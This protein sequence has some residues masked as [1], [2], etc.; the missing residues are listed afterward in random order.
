MSGRILAAL[1]TIPGRARYLRRVLFSL[2]PQVDRL[3]VYLNGYG[4]VPE[5]VA[6]LADEHVVDGENRGAERKFHWSERHRGLYFSCDDDL[7]YPP[8]YVARMLA[9]VERW[10]GD[11]IVTLHG[12]SYDGRPT[13]ISHVVPD[14]IGVFTNRLREGRWVNHGGTGVM[15][16]DSRRVRIP[17]EWH[18]HNLADMQVSAWAQRNQVPIW[19]AARERNWVRSL[20]PLDP[21]G[22]YSSSRREGHERRNKILVDVGSERGWRV[23]QASSCGG[24]SSMNS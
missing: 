2:R 19:L 17:S 5:A 24:T 8:D 9:E 10:N 23:F 3:C 20:L 12:R 15:A 16:W 21:D 7:V 13:H 11:A 18:S 22:I 4:N 6:E 14:S 1:A